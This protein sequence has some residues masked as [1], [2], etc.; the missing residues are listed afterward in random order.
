MTFTHIIA[1]E[2]KN[3]KYRFEAVAADGTKHLIRKAGNLTKGVCQWKHQGG[4]Y[5][6][7]F[8]YSIAEADERT[9]KV[10]TPNNGIEVVPYQA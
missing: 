7:D 4:D 9:I 2:L 3:G 6:Y 10:F 8:T 5:K 1:T